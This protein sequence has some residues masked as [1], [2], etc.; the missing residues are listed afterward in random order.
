MEYVNHNVRR[1]LDEIKREELER[2][3]RLA[4]REYELENNLDPTRPDFADHLDHQNPHKFEIEDLKK[5]I[6]KV[7]KK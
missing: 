4:M 7:S 3:R 1:K 5:L 6:H 2:L